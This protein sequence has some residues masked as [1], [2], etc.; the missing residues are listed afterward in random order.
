MNEPWLDEYGHATSDPKERAREFIRRLES[1]S[2]LSAPVNCPVC[3]HGFG[4][5]IRDEGES[6]IHAAFVTVQNQ[7]QGTAMPMFVIR[8]QRCPFMF[9]FDVGRNGFGD[10]PERDVHNF[11]L[12]W[13]HHEAMGPFT[14]NSPWWISGEGDKGTDAEG[15]DVG[16]FKSICAA[17]KARDI[18][19]AMRM[20]VE[21]YDRKPVAM[22]WRF[23]KPRPKDWSP[24][25]ERF[26]QADWMVW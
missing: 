7:L 26:P 10:L 20:V 5:D 2:G 17:I 14:L 12:S 25:S 24:F 19:E 13:E 1:L 3:G 18:K 4:W 22:E 15:N 21:A 6:E 8:C 23:T 16:E 11:W 9:V